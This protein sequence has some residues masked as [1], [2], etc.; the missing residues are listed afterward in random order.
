MAAGAKDKTDTH[1]I[2]LKGEKTH[3]INRE[4]SAADDFRFGKDC[5]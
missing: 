2:A 4:K 5:R 1:K 3:A